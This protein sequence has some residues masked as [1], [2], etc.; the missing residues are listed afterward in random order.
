MNT[1]LSHTA[2][3]SALLFALSGGAALHAQQVLYELTP[4]DFSWQFG[5]AVQTLGDIDGDGSLDFAVGSEVGFTAL[6]R[7]QV[8]SGASGARLYGLV[9]PDVAHYWGSSL[10]ALDDRDGDGVAELVIGAPRSG[11]VGQSGFV[12]IRSGA[13]GVLLDT[14]T[15]PVDTTFAERMVTVGDL[16]GDGR[17]DLLVGAPYNF[18]NGGGPS[19]V[20]VLSGA[21]GAPLYSLF[22]GESDGMGTSLSPLPDL[23]HD[24][25]GDFA[26]G[27][28]QAAQ[29][30]SGA[31]GE[32]LRRFEASEPFGN[33]GA[34]IAP[35]ADLDGDGEIDLAV[36]T[37]FDMNQAGNP[38]GHVDVYSTTTG[39][40]LATLTP[41]GRFGAFGTTLEPVGDLDRDGQVDLAVGQKGFYLSGSASAVHVYSGADASLLFTTAG[42]SAFEEFGTSI[43]PLGDVNGDGFLDLVAGAPGARVAR[44][45]TYRSLTGDTYCEAV[46][47]STG[48]AA[49]IFALG[50]PSLGRNHFTLLAVPVPAGKSGVFFY[51]S[52]RQQIP[53]GPGFLCVAPGAGGMKRLALR[54]SDSSGVLSLAVDMPARFQE[55]ESW[56]FQAFFRDTGTWRFGLSDAVGVSF[57]H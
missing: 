20:H 49:E 26:V 19:A 44:V 34:A 10:A 22:A 12:E 36:S 40:L 32:L 38:V 39:I 57:L 25:V 24:G 11:S 33:F 16:D 30:H 9:G 17:R 6:D 5:Q 35:W 37:S 23:N 14:W 29:I 55:G 51:G 45:L 21:D 7:V 3:T 18:H 50:S 53:F 28:L 15:G 2:R 31:T 43:A 1:I 56:N 13:T 46:A 27:L 8:F 41:P 42:T 54:M 52:G 4:A 47:N 48:A